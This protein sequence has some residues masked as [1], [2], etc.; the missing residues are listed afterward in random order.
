MASEEARAPSGVDTGQANVARVYDYW[1]GGTSNFRADQDAARALIAVE[2]NA[3]Q[4]ARANRAFLG[5]AVRFLA[6]S[7]IRQFLDIG[8]GIPTQRNVHEVAQEAAPGSRVVYV[9]MDPVVVAHSQAILDGREDAVAIQA[10]LR[11]PEE[12]L[13]H[14]DTRRLIDFG[15]PVGLL[16]VAVLHFIPAA[17]EARRLVGVLRD[18]LAP[19]SY[20]TIC[21]GTNETSRPDV[22]EAVE[23]V[24]NRRV[25]EPVALRS[26][27]EILRFFDGFDL[28]QPGLVFLPEWRPDAT[29][30]VPD[31]PSRMWGLVGVGMLPG[32][33]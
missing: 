33:G 8:S 16:L 32:P 11:E 22:A 21:H 31:D 18:R 29:V 3:R 2:P 13:D 12:I 14:P 27:A 30:D 28:V 1:L 20:L 19:G 25:T 10:D 9:D 15:Q 26:R 7:G 17:G 4:I 24:Y 23:K 5:R 6:A